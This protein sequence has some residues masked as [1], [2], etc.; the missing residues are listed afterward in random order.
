MKRQIV[1][2][3]PIHLTIL[4]IA[5]LIL[6][7]ANRMYYPFLPVF[8]RGLGV[9][10]ETLAIVLS[11]RQG[12]GVFAPLFGS[13]GD[14]LG[15]KSSVLIGLGLFTLSFSFVAINP[16][17]ETIFI[18]LLV[19]SIATTIFNP[20]IYAFIGDQVPRSRHRLVIGI[21]EFSWSGALIIGIPII[22]FII[23]K[24]N[25]IAPFPFLASLAAVTTLMVWFLIPKDISGKRSRVPIFKTLQSVFSHPQARAILVVYLLTGTGNGVFTIIYG[26]WLE[27]AFG[28][29]IASLSAATALMGIAELIGEGVMA[30]LSDRVSGRLAIA[31]GVGSNIVASLALILLGHS[32]LGAL[33]GLFMFFMSYEFCLVSAFPYIIELV[34]EARATIMASR[35][36]THRSGL[37]IG[38]LIGPLIF[39]YGYQINLVTV[40]FMDLIAIVILR[41]CIKEQKPEL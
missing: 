2:K 27:N 20:A 13:A 6:S 5:R 19:A 1:P 3:L 8:A 29:T 18:A 17:F 10:I 16:T 36:A 37:A 12:L 34:P 25:W 26:A 11:A 41:L 39:H 7:T 15:R 38:I 35:S 4:S 21:T 33:V 40:I 14:F 28:L 31:L 22:G 32:V 9:N 23:A 24:Y 30:G